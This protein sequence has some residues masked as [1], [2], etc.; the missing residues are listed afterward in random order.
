MKRL[1]ALA[2]GLWLPVVALAANPATTFTGT[3]V[4]NVNP[5]KQTVSIKTKE[6]QSWTLRVAD[7]ELLKK[8]NLRKGDKV[9]LE[10]DTN[11]N[12]WRAKPEFSRESV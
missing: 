6:G 4:K 12:R 3:T 9:S 5:G 7:P 2:I 1:M 8:H 10:V 11:N